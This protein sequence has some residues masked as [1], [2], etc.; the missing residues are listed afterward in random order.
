MDRNQATGLILMSIL[1]LLY[2][3]FFGGQTEAPQKE[4]TTTEQVETPTANNQPAT[5]KFHH[6]HM[7]ERSECFQMQFLS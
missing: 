6:P 3:S 1:L 5:L 4:E 7:L 2:F